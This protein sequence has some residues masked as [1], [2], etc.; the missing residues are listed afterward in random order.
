MRYDVLVTRYDFD[1]DTPVTGKVAENLIEAEA[2]AMVTA[3][4]ESLHVFLGEWAEMIPHGAE[5][6][7]GI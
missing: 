4:M 2:R 3:K 5:W 1:L 6:A 7:T